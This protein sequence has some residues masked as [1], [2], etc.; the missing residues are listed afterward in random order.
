LVACLAPGG[1]A[2][3]IGLSVPPPPMGAWLHA[4]NRE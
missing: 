3:I 4:L 2:L 1:V